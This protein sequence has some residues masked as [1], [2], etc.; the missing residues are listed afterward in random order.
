[1]LLRAVTL[2]GGLAGAAGFSQ[3]PEFSQQYVQRLGGAVD[4][5]HRVVAGFDADAAAL[6]LTRAQ[7]LGALAQGGAMGEKRVEAMRGIMARHARLAGDLAALERA[8]PFT[9]AYYA[10]HLSDREIAARAWAAYKPAVPM[11]FEGA[12]FGGVGFL[13]GALLLGGVIGVLRRGARRI[14]R[15]GRR[16]GAGADKVAAAASA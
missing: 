11:T 3:F 14:S 5:L 12:V 8:G 4:E 1:M 6:E 15:R 16:R 13:G 2:A 7:A 9:R 10:A